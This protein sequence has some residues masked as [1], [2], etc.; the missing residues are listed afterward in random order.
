MNEAS[1]WLLDGLA[2]A[3]LGGLHFGGLWWTVR[4]VVR[5]NVPG[6]WL[7]ISLV[8]R[9]ALSAVVLGFVSAG[10]W[11]GLLAGLAGFLMAR[12][13]GVRLARGGPEVDSAPQ[14]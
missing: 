8:L 6:T 7:L 9:S 14:P 2:G 1:R 5:S 13:A 10:Q 3:L 11:Q 4:R 12:A